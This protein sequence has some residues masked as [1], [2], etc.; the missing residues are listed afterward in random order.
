VAQLPLAHGKISHEVL[1][2][3]MSLKNIV[4]CAALVAWI[5]AGG[6]AKGKTG[7]DD[8][9]DDDVAGQP[10][11]SAGDI[12]GSSCGELCDQDG[13]GVLD[14]NDACPA[15]PSGD[16]VNQVGCS[17]SQVTPTLEPDF[18]PFGLTWTPTGDLGRAGGL[19]W[20]YTGID[21]ADLFHIYWIVCDDPATPCGLSL[22]GAVD[23]LSEN[24]Q[25]S[26]PASDLA[27]GRLVFTNTTHIV[28][29]DSST[30][31]LNGR[32][33]VTI[34]D[35]SNASIPFAYLATLGVTGRAGQFGSE[36]PG[37]GYKVVALAEVQDPSSGSWVPYLDY[38]DAAP[39][40]ETGGSTATSFGGSFYAE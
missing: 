26:A 12:D 35:A 1:E 34:F 3:T 19:T 30:P 29:A 11:A 9:D 4:L 31:Q 39:T 6:C 32:L 5:G 25:A 23:G 15:T 13:D 36:I 33:T 16:V 7:G 28:L 17:V 37:T 8:G 27:A 40:P 38:Y 14:P 10:D 20:T 21:R 2:G 24:W 18:P 22:D